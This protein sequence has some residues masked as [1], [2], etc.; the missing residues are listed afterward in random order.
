MIEQHKNNLIN[1]TVQGDG[2][3]VILI[4]GM[5]ASLYDWEAMIPEL[6]GAGYRTYAVDLLGHGDSL[7]P[8]EPGSYH[9]KTVYSYL[10]QWIDKLNLE[11]PPFMVGH[12]MGAYFSM[13]YGLRNPQKLLAMALVNPFYTPQQLSPV[14][15]LLQR[16]PKLGEKALRVVPEWIFHALAMMRQLPGIHGAERH[17]QAGSIAEGLFIIPIQCRVAQSFD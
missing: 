3:P 12:S 16:R 1:Y 11:M 14:V 2:P 17:W 5:G 10:E 7:K 9:S 4:H 6:V 13:R 8:E 15:R